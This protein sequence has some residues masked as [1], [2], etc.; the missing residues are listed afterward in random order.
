M[1][2]MDGYFSTLEK[3]MN[4]RIIGCR[5]VHDGLKNRPK[6]SEL[7]GQM[8]A[9]S[10]DLEAALATMM[11]GLVASEAVAVMIIT[12]KSNSISF[13]TEMVISLIKE[14]YKSEEQQALILNCKTLKNLMVVRNKLVHGV[15]GF[16]EDM[17]NDALLSNIKHLRE[18]H[19]SIAQKKES[20]INPMPIEK[21]YVIT[22]QGLKNLIDDMDTLRNTIRKQFALF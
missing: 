15:W 5:T 21:T 11:S 20:Q 19:G 12:N 17:K 13:V 9:S 2:R 6:I 4:G 1:V 22:E 7:F 18:F 8:V 3:E 16:S 14:K 10:V